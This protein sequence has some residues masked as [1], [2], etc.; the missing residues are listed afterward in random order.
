M[1]YLFELCFLNDD[2]LTENVGNKQKL[3][4]GLLG[5]ILDD[6]VMSCSVCAM[7]VGSSYNKFNVN[8]DTNSKIP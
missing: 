3:P 6:K 1:K 2:K 5:A 4:S 8:Q 7:N